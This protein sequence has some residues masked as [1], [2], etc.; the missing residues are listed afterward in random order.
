MTF[1][2]FIQISNVSNRIVV[3][4]TS[5][6]MNYLVVLEAIIKISWNVNDY[7]MKITIFPGQHA[8]NSTYN[9]K[10]RISSHLQK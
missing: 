2:R 10:V 1:I 3:V 9:I 5:L 7:E 4:Q 8:E 6:I